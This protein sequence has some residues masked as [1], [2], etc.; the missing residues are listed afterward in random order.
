L[1]ARIDGEDVPGDDT[2]E[3][4]AAGGNSF[5]SS[6]AFGGEVLVGDRGLIVLLQRSSVRDGA[7]L[8]IWQRV[9]S[10]RFITLWTIIERSCHEMLRK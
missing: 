10:R 5:L 8:R 9:G 3:S 1:R 4:E 2:E 6:G 7:F